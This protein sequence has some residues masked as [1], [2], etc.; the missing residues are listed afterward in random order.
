MKRLILLKF[1]LLILITSYG[2]QIKTY[3]GV[4]EIKNKYNAFQNAN[5]HAVYQYYQDDKYN[6]IY[7]GSFNLNNGEIVGRY[8]NNQRVGVWKWTIKN[9]DG[10]FYNVNGTKV[11]YVGN[12]TTIYGT[13]KNGLRDGKWVYEKAE[14]ISGKIIKKSIVT[15]K[16]DT[17]I[18]PYNY[19]DLTKKLSDVE[20]NFVV[21]G[22]FDSKGALDG[23]W[24]TKYYYNKF[25]CED[26]RKYKNGILSFEVDRNLAT[27]EVKET[28]NEA[29]LVDKIIAYL[30]SSAPES[31]KP[32]RD[33]EF[34]I[35]IDGEF[36]RLKSN[37]FN[38]SYSDT[39]LFWYYFPDKIQPENEMFDY[40]V[41]GNKLSTVTIIKFIDKL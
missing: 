9:P 39:F 34:N 40:E 19:L 33:D 10:F 7:Q 36:Y 5:N 18:G 24:I 22:Q 21:S 30:D 6:R 11:K 3:N 38:L 31:L 23:T 20:S 27:G 35:K 1:L 15:F 13:Y 41:P 37:L 28:H 32:V 2:Q 16:N 26:L 4:Y 8:F 17:I 14:R 25:P 29:D 12:I